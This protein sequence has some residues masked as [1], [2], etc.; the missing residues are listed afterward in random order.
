MKK[1]NYSSVYHAFK[2]YH[3]YLR[4]RARL[5]SAGFVS[6]DKFNFLNKRIEKIQIFLSAVLKK[7]KMA[8]AAAS[9]V[10]TLNATSANGQTFISP[11][12]N[13]FG[14]NPTNAYRSAPAFADLDGDGD[15]DMISGSWYGQFLY[16]ENT[17]T[18]SAPVFGP[19]QTNPFG[20]LNPGSFNVNTTPTFGDLD[21]DGDFDMMVG[22]NVG[23]GMPYDYASGNIYYYENTGDATNPAFTSPV[24]NAFGIVIPSYIYA[25]P[26]YNYNYGL[27]DRSDPA[28]VDIDN[29]GDLDMYVGNNSGGDLYF[30]ENTGSASSPAFAAPTVE[31]SLSTYSITPSFADFDGD[32]DFDLFEGETYGNVYY[33]ENTGTNVAPVFAAAVMNP[34]TNL[35]DI[36]NSSNLALVDL[37]NDGDWDIMSGEDYSSFY[38]FEQCTAPVAPS[39]DT[40]VEDLS[41]CE[42]ESTTLMA[43]GVGTL[44]WYDAPT[45][46]TYLGGGTSFNTGSLLAD[47]TYYV[48]DSTCV[49][50]PRTA[51]DVSVNAVPDVSTTLSGITISAVMSGVTYQWVN[52]P[53]YTNASG[54]STNQSYTPTANGQFAVIVNNSGCQDTSACTTISS[55]GIDDQELSDNLLVYPNPSTGNFTIDLGQSYNEVMILITNSLGQTVKLEQYNELQL[56]EISLQSESGIYFVEITNN[57]GLRSKVKLIIE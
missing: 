22:S 32:G 47:A 34:F 25:G 1:K 20:L 31:L 37:D 56:I 13:P 51:I 46:G 53:A 28:L 44:G 10:L 5:I 55:V 27:A 11:V 52:C 54:V 3:R 9:V 45:G 24:T 17:G 7:S 23:S 4:K 19:T 39:N 40:P 49:E 29:D 8:T 50:G 35:L 6:G 57:E 14:L 16:Y 18:A 26:Y 15:Q 36:G 33:S 12:T 30:Y 42:G 2:S 41:L 21:G 43:G 38:Y 48:Q